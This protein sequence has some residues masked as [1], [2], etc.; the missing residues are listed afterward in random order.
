MHRQQQGWFPEFISSRAF[1][2]CTRGKRKSSLWRSPNFRL[3]LS[4]SSILLFH[5]LLFR[6]FTRLRASLRS[7]DAKPFRR[8]N[9]RV[10]RALTSRL[11]PAVGASTA[12]LFLGISA[13]DQTRVTVAIYIFS[14]SLEFLYENMLNRGYFKS[15]PWWFGSWLI[16]PAACGQLLHAFVFDR[17][18][19]P[20]A[21]GGFILKRSPEYIQ[22]AP[23]NHPSNL[24]WPS[25]FDIVDSLGEMSKLKWPPFV[26][27]ILFPKVRTLPQSVLKIAPITDPA[28]PAIKR[29]SCAV[30]HPND[31]SCLRTWLKYYISAFP[32][33]AKFWTVIYVALSIP[34]YRLFMSMPLTALNGLAG[35][36]LRTTIYLTGAIGTAWSS[37][38]LLQ[39]ILPRKVLPTGRWFLSGFLAGLWAY[40]DRSSGRSGYLYSARTSIDSTWKVGRK[41]GWWKGVKNGDVL[42]FTLCL[43][44]INCIYERDPK[45]VNSGV[46]RKGMGIFRGDGWV[47]R[48]LLLEEQ[49]KL[50]AEKKQL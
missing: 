46:L 16:M 7:E 23:P 36:I 34:R 42:L 11:A 25:T 3:S 15:K 26:S 27:P 19:F 45:A 18:C 31:P 22:Q 43:A 33:M 35:K 48:A 29:L 20:T 47:D 12:G 30:L 49:K 39:R 32:A 28:H 37:I 14:R 21:Y 9:P 8:R 4:L 24:A 10:W 38:C 6:F 41:K 13:A 5:R 17:D 40:V 44:L 2:D 1:A 50:E